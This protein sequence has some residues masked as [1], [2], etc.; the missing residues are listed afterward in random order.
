MFKIYQKSQ[1]EIA[2]SLSIAAN[3]QKAEYMI[4][5]AIEMLV[6]L[7]FLG[8]VGVF[9]KKDKKHTLFRIGKILL[10]PVGIIRNNSKILKSFEKAIDFTSI[11][12][13]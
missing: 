3:N 13:Y 4:E 7:V 12:E 8:C 6:L 1:S 10:L 9:F 5:M 11:K 2:G